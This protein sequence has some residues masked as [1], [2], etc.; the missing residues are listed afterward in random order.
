MQIKRGSHSAVVLKEP[1]WAL[2]TFLP[3]FGEGASEDIS[4]HAKTF[5]RLL[6]DHTFTFLCLFSIFHTVGEA[7]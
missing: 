3:A 7:K 6:G 1:E 5:H 2:T 4:K